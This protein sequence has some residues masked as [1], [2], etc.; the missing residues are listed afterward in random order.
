[1]LN[2]LYSIMI[3]HHITFIYDR[4]LYNNQ[5]KILKIY[6]IL[7]NLFLYICKFFVNIY[8]YK[9]FVSSISFIFSAVLLSAST[10][11]TS[12]VLRINTSTLPSAS[13]FLPTLTLTG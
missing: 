4:F 8:T 2:I 9:T 12:L 10:K 3:K 11:I 13:A 7:Y 5:A 1:M 6:K